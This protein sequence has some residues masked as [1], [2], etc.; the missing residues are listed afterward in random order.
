M[1]LPIK[2]HPKVTAIVEAKDLTELPLD[3]LIGNLKVYEMI[4]ENDDEV[5]MNKKDNVKSLALKAKIIRDEY[6]D[7]SDN[8]EDCEEVSEVVD[9]YNLMVK[10]FKR[11]K[12]MRRSLEVLE[13]IVKTVIK[14][15]RTKRVSWRLNRKRRLFTSY[16]E[17]DGGHVM[18]R[19]NLKGKVTGG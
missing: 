5:F 17:Y 18:S 11:Q 13:V 19:S 16:K 6:S 9:E 7:D 2:W 15:R 14:R 4:L 3:E 10:N 8:Q 1:A 12:R